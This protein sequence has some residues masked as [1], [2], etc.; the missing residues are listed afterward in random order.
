MKDEKLY[1]IH[2]SECIERID[3]YTESGKDAFMESDLIQDAVIRNL[4]VMSESTMR[5]SDETQEMYPEVEW[6][7]IRGFRN[8]LVHDYLGTD[9]ERVWMIIENDLPALKT[10]VQKMILR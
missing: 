1:I 9:L 5:L 6:F 2:I 8:V 10:V 3:K 4:Q 7:K